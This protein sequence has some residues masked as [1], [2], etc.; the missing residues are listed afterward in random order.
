M[1]IVLIGA[2]SR[3]FGFGQIR[4]LMV[5]SELAEMNVTLSLVD[6]DS[7]ALKLMARVAAR[8]KEQTGS[9][10]EIEATTDRRKALPGADYV[11]TVVSIR[12]WELWEQEFRI[13]TAYGF[14]QALGENGGPAALF[15]TMRSL[16][17]IIPICSDIEELCPDAWLF[18]FTNPEAR[19]LSAILNHTNV[20][21]AG[22]CHG[23][24][25]ALEYIEKYTGKTRDE[26]DV[27]SAGINHFYAILKAT[28]RATGEDLLPL[29][30]EKAIADEHA[31]PLFRK[32]AE[33]MDVF[34]FPSEDHI[35]EYLAFGTSYIG[36]RW[37]FGI[38]HQR[39]TR[40]SE[41]IDR[42]LE[43]IAESGKISDDHLAPSGELT[44]P[45]IADMMFDRK[46]FRPAV[47]VLNTG[48]HI[49][50]LPVSAAIEIP[51]IVDKDGLHP[52]DV[53]ALP[54]GFASYVRAQLT[55]TETAV[56]AWR[57]K[58]RKLLLRALLL[59]PVVTNVEAA[60]KMLDELLEL[61]L[62]FLPDFT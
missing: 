46:N 47:N 58:S 15:H 37:H 11:I 39:I 26:L 18:N 14:N 42:W 2:G 27:H 17:L 22:F 38:E 35:G 44:V 56:E 51:A 4:D 24:F 10:I 50:N 13:S 5:A 40:E 41:P 3:S 20:K 59:D 53:G 7:S 43:D 49:S 32:F 48:G 9:G 36:T 12:R 57:L 28:N 19:V 45:I 6:T 55:I 30:L 8:L 1:K 29:L 54:E 61:Q 60:E 33:I 34:T 16:E 31:P 25:T 62:D 52:V 21:A 23:V